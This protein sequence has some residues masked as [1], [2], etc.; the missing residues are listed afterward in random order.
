ML[1]NS[2]YV[3]VL[4]PDG[5]EDCPVFTTFV[6]TSLCDEFTYHVLYDQ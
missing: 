5:A 6:A 1:V 3:Y 2:V 4:V